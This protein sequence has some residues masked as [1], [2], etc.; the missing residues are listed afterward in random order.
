MIIIIQPFGKKDKKVGLIPLVEHLVLNLLLSKCVNIAFHIR[1]G[2]AG[3][4][5]IVCHTTHNYNL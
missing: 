4:Y 1:T 3:I 2:A 5:S